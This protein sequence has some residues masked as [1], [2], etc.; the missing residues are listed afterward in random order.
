MKELTEDNKTRVWVKLRLFST[1]TMKVCEYILAKEKRPWQNQA[2]KQLLNSSVFTVPYYQTSLYTRPNSRSQMSLVATNFY[3]S[4][5]FF[6]CLFSAHIFYLFL[7]SSFPAFIYSL[8]LLEHPLVLSFLA[9]ELP[10]S[11]QLCGWTSYCNSRRVTNCICLFPSR[12][13]VFRR[14]QMEKEEG[15]RRNGEKDEKERENENINECFI[16]SGFQLVN[17]GS[18]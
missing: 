10:F 14:R 16:F 1:N 5:S 11:L 15:M 9:G 2:R 4:I 12:Q 18:N 3:S 13:M 17:L 8:M 6:F 7:S